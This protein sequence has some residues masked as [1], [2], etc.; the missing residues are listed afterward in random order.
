MTTLSE[1]TYPCINPVVVSILLASSDL[2][3]TFAPWIMFLIA[4]WG[5]GR[6]FRSGERAEVSDTQ[7]ERDWDERYEYE[8]DEI[9]DDLDDY[10]EDE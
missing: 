10:E 7:N 5:I 3:Y 1:N 2:L 4:L 6:L 8:D 9:D